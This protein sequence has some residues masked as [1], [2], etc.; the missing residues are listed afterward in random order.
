MRVCM[1]LY[2]CG[3]MYVVCSNVKRGMEFLQLYVWMDKYGQMCMFGE[4]EDLETRRF[5]DYN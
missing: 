3:W 1:I 4:E 2:V 5:E